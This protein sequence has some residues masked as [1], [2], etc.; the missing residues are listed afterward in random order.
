MGV[1]NLTPWGYDAQRQSLS[2]AERAR[3]VAGVAF[4]PYFGVTAGAAFALNRYS[5]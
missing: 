1:V 5:R 4:S 2:V 3:L